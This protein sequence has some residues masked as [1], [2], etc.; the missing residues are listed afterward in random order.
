MIDISA[1]HNCGFKAAAGLKIFDTELIQFP[2]I[3]R[4]GAGKFIELTFDDE[5][6]SGQIFAV[7]SGKFLFSFNKAQ[8]PQQPAFKVALLPGML[9]AD[10]NCRVLKFGQSRRVRGILTGAGN[11]IL[12]L[13]MRF[14]MG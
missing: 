8:V 3:K 11:R 7:H 1:A 4:I 13:R 14:T 5:P 12:T 10:R 6:E 2:L 9:T